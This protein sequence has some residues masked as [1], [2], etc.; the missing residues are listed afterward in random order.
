MNQSPGADVSTTRRWLIALLVLG[1]LALVTLLPAC[2]D[3][4]KPTGPSDGELPDYPMFM[5]RAGYPSPHYIY[6]PTSNRLD[7]FCLV[8][9]PYMQVSADGKYLY[10][11][12]EDS[13]QVAAFLVDSL[14][15][16]DT[17]RVDH[18]LPLREITAVS[19][20]NLM[21]AGFTTDWEFAIIRKSDYSA[22][23]VA[24]D[25]FQGVFIG[26]SKR[27][28]GRSGNQVVH[29][30]LEG[31]PRVIRRWE[32]LFGRLDHLVPTADESLWLMYVKVG[33]GFI[34]YFLAYDPQADSVLYQQFLTPGYG[35]IEAR[36]G[37]DEYVFTNGGQGYIGSGPAPP[38]YF[39]VFDA[40]TVTAKDT[41]L[42][43]NACYDLSPLPIKEV[44]YT[45]DGKW[46]VAIHEGFGA[47][48]VY[49]AQTKEL[50]HC[51]DHGNDIFGYGLITQTLP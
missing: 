4:K 1:L 15:S 27:F 9:G 14:G 7:S 19:P 37:T 10:A 29:I 24:D 22:V 18:M 41:V 50:S 21:L 47:I 6:Y 28:Y 49:D 25:T 2:S 36:S 35:E 51:L 34:F 32:C 33:V 3:T 13:A 26:G 16:G 48:L 12:P 46:L 44:E 23:F 45:A 30:D 40:Q 38:P 42:S 20:D 5:T 17:A 11:R 8:K 31:T 39:H 43:T